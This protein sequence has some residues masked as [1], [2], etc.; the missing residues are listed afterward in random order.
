MKPLYIAFVWNQH[1][2]YYQDTAKKEYIMPWVRLHATKDYYAMAAILRDYPN[3]RQTFNLTP[4]LV[5]QL[6]DYIHGA[7]DYYLRVMKPVAELSLAEKRFLLQH[8]FDIQWDRVIAR[9]PR[10]NQLLA[11]QGR[12][13]EPTSLG[14]AINRFT[15]Q[16][17]LDLQVWFNL[18]WIDPAEREQDAELCALQKKGKNYTEADKGLVLKKQWEIM[19]QVVPIHRLLAEQGQIELI[20]TPYYHPIM[21]LLID[22]R[23]ALRASPGLRLP[24]TYCYP[25]NAAEQTVRAINQYR[26][27]FGNHPKGVWPPEQAVSPET[28][29]LFA[30]HGFAW[31]ITDEDILARSLKTEIYRDSFGHVLN[32]DELYRPY[33]VKAQGKEMAIIFRDHH[34][35]DRIGFVYHQMCM[36]HAVEDLIHR[37]HKIRESVANCEGPHLVTIALDGEN[38][39]EWY[40]ND[41]QEFLHKL[42]GKLSRNTLLRTVTVS[43]YLENY[44]PQREIHNLHSGSWVDHSVTRW[45][46][47]D[48][49]NRLWEMLLDAR[50]MVEDARGTVGPEK[51]TQAKENIMIAEGSDYT[52]WVDSMP[53]Y[54]AAPFEALFRK[55]LM[56]AYRVCGRTSPG[57]LDEPVIHPQHGE[58]AWVDN[59][60]VGPTA[61]VQAKT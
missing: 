61:M 42:Y 25:E 5:A 45:I 43:E 55:H 35:S 47:S 56:N 20:T 9:W 59:P 16:D 26:R 38:A 31:T 32:A 34:L 27:Y 19:G 13:K 15:D 2:P 28:V 39:W 4:S 11:K 29:A 18:V 51:L 1:Q 40:P 54:L 33:R 14:S 12:C 46:G 50:Q 52:W 24:R 48:S 21:P 49:K 3:I 36:D 60:L 22:T 57:Y 17:Y 10:Y 30:D 58:P 41:K 8:Y 7:D 53:Y 6:E 44:P 23:S 37:F